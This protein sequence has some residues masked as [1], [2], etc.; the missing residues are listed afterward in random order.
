M[1][2]DSRVFDDFTFNEDLYHTI[3]VQWT[4]Y[5]DCSGLREYAKKLATQ[6]D[7]TKPFILLGVSMGG[8]LAMEMSQ[9]VNPDKIILISSAKSQKEIPFKY[10]IGR[11]LPLYGLVNDKMLHSIANKKSTYKDIHDTTDQVLYKK[12]LLNCGADFLKWQMKS[13]CQWKFESNNLPP[14]FHIH[15]DKDNILPIRKIN[16][17]VVI[18]NGTHKMVINYPKKLIDI[19]QNHMNQ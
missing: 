13:I 2:T 1:G 14:I 16:C 12:M 7:T 10:K 5:H 18:E 8:M 17:N 19:I 6:I 4:D 11:V 3:P 15:G 9:I